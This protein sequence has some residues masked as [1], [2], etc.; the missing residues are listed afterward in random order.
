MTPAQIADERIDAYMGRLDDALAKLSP[1][2][3]E[4]ILREIHTHIVES[5]AGAS[6]RNGC[7]PGY[8][9]GG[10]RQGLGYEPAGSGRTD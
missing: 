3:R 9:I 6:D 4:D 8:A 7:R 1:S 2:D 10:G 5:S